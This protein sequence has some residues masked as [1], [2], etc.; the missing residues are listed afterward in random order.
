MLFKQLVF[1]LST[2]IFV[3]SMAIADCKAAEE[4]VDFPRSE[5]VGIEPC[6]RLGTIF[7][8]YNEISTRA[9]FLIGT[10]AQE[11]NVYFV[12]FK[13]AAQRE[14]SIVERGGVLLSALAVLPEDDRVRS[15]AYKFAILR[16][17]GLL[18][19][20][21]T[22]QS[23]VYVSAFAFALRSSL[24]KSGFDS[25]AELDCFIAADIPSLSV[26]S[27]MASRFFEDCLDEG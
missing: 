22:N 19:E 6:D 11:E 1:A 26:E 10:S 8:R 5:L 12:L 7:L 13:S 25:V 21:S 3:P 23:G 24:S 20:S 15:E 14:L 16:E 4:L 17:Y 9:N 2:I 27:I 18:A